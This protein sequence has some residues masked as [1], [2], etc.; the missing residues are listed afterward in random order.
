MFR[1]AAF[2]VIILLVSG[3]GRARAEE[4]NV[5][6]LT[7]RKDK[8]RVAAVQMKIQDEFL[9]DHDTV[10]ALIPHIERAGREGQ[11]LI[12]FPEYLLGNFKI[13]S[14]LV[15]KLCEQ[16]KK[17]NV[18]VIAAGW[19]FLP[20]API[21]HPPLP[22]TYANTALIIGRD[23]KLIGTYRKIHEAVGAHSPFCWPPDKG[24]MGEW[25]MLAGREHPV[26][27]MDFGRIG[28]LT[29]YDGYFFSSFEIPSLK[30][31]EILVWI[32]SRM[33][34]VEPHIIQAASF[35]T[36]THIVATNFEGGG[37]TG[38]C[39]H[40]GWQTE[41][42]R[43]PGFA[44]VTTELDLAGLRVQRRN[45]RM[46]HQRKPELYGDLVKRWKPWEAYPD[47]PMQEPYDPEKDTGKK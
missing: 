10:D 42:V 20:D 41:Q 46:F 47:I 13:E 31:A 14:P 6:P 18:N 26:F 5:T 27:D 2:L 40:P 3:P 45:Y 38:F 16:A 32:N 39:K 28:V 1:I 4:G 11:D 33:G 8:V 21:Q 12:V 19:E 30:G 7:S 29:C 24:E 23:G 15:R 25:T 17:N 35:M 43:E 44:Y 9:K 34:M 37:G 36:C 22:R